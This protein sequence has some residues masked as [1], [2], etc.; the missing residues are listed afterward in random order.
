[1]SKS[2]SVFY[3][4]LVFILQLVMAHYVNLGPWVHI[5]LLPLLVLVLPEQWRTQ[6]TMLVAFALG[7]LLDLLSGGPLGLNSAAAVLAATPRKMMLERKHPNPLL[8]LVVMTALYLLGYF[9]LDGVSFHPFWFMPVKLLASLAAS[10]A[11]SAL[12]L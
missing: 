11:V 12:L 2:N 9:L 1:M 5:S 7:L 8:C 10:F 6:R 3:F 4:V